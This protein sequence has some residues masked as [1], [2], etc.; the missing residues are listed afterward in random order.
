MG[1]NIVDF[2]RELQKEEY[3]FLWT[4]ERLKSN[5]ILLAV[6]GSHAYG[7]NIEGS[8]IDMRGICLNDTDAILGMGSSFEQYEDRKTDTVVYTATKIIK[9]LAN[10]NPNI[11]EML[12]CKDEH[13]IIKNDLGKLIL[14]NKELFLSKKAYYTFSQY[15]KDQ[16][17][18]L[19]S[20][21][22]GTSDNKDT[23]L[24]S[25]YRTLENRVDSFNKRNRNK[26]ELLYT[27]NGKDDIRFRLYGESLEIADLGQIANEITVLATNINKLRKGVSNKKPANI[28]KHAM[29]LV[30]LHLMCIDILE[31]GQINTY[32]ENELELLMDIRENG[33]QNTDGTLTYK[34]IRLKD[35]LELDVQKA[36]DTTSLPDT[37]DM[38][39]INDLLYQINIS[40][41][42]RHGI[43]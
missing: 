27:V 15:A 28:N 13:Y 43:V 6:G 19:E 14:D 30:R 26:A 38:S 18:R 32:R 23:Q 29:H 8:D 22:A 34:F 42:E 33:V 25:L 17:N 36:N 37:P 21:L 3:D 7:T 40:T 39:K 31:H 12:G 20:A 16:L 41:L 11:I 10:C 2:K 35:K 4:E 9:L 24:E 5:I 1:K